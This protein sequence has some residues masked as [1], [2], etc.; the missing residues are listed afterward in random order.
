M[1]NSINICWRPTFFAHFLLLL[2][3][4][5]HMLCL[6]LYS[7]LQ[8]SQHSEIKWN[9]FIEHAKHVDAIEILIYFE[10]HPLHTLYNKSM[11]FFLCQNAY[12]ANTKSIAHSLFSILSHLTRMNVSTAAAVA[13][14]KYRTIYSKYKW[15][16]IKI[17]NFRLF[18]N[19]L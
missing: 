15:N 5:L 14:D 3:Q 12:S 4:S 2:E 13:D 7:P 16:V 11:C 17:D 6:T 8:F 10:A 19:L 9:T 1:H 18:K